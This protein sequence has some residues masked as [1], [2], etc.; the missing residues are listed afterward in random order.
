[1]ILFSKTATDQFQSCEEQLVAETQNRKRILPLGSDG[2]CVSIVDFY[3]SIYSEYVVFEVTSSTL[4][5]T[6][7]QSGDKYLSLHDVIEQLL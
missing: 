1:M 4:T 3:F 2:G 6:I 7:T 5:L